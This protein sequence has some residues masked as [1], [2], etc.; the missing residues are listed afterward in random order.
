[1]FKST[2][3]L[4]GICYLHN[5][6]KSASSSKWI[7]AFVNMLCK[8]PKFSISPYSIRSSNFSSHTQAIYLDFLQR[9]WLST[10]K[11]NCVNL[12][13]SS[14]HDLTTHSIA[15]FPASPLLCSYCPYLQRGHPAGL[16]LSPEVRRFSPLFRWVRGSPGPVD[17]AEEPLLTE[18]SAHSQP[19]DPQA[20]PICAIRLLMISS[21]LAHILHI[22]YTFVWNRFLYS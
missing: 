18:I 14:F 6:W 21:T 15:A 5:F 1:M 4:F 19:F 10:L 2:F 9:C 12:N 7:V 16:P 3:G 20:G 8:H 13:S 22:N 17:G 11:S